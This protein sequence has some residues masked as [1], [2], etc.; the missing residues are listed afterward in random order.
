MQTV[1]EEVAQAVDFLVD[2]LQL[3]SEIVIKAG[4]SMMVAMHQNHDPQFARFVD[5][6]RFDFQRS[7]DRVLA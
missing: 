2:Q 4:I 1:P 3:P 6:V 5:A 7:V